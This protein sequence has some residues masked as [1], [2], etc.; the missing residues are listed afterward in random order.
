MLLESYLYKQDPLI[1]QK[2]MYVD[3]RKHDVK[4]LKKGEN[5]IYFLRS[6]TF[7]TALCY[8]YIQILC[9]AVIITDNG[10]VL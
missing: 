9:G 7:C 4:N 2:Y 6:K 1:W 8:I 10:S 3:S 5:I